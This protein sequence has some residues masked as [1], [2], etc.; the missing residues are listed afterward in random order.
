M[1]TEKGPAPR[2]QRAPELVG[3]AA[4]HRDVS[5]LSDRGVAIMALDVALRTS[6]AIRRLTDKFTVFLRTRDEDQVILLKELPALG[7][8]VAALESARRE[9]LPSVRPEASSW[10]DWD[11]SLTKA[12]AVLS[13][14]V[15]DPHDRLDSVRAREIA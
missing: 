12:A 8:R 15:K 6:I 13:Q 5:G 11:E 3:E 4:E 9:G 10:H 1:T 2:P 7:G 14:R